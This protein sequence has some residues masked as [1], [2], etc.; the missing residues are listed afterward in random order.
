MHNLPKKKSTLNSP[1][2]KMQTL[3]LYKPQEQNP[4]SQISRES[5]KHNNFQILITENLI[6]KNPFNCTA[7]ES[8]L[9]HIFTIN[10]YQKQIKNIYLQG[11][12]DLDLRKDLQ[13]EKLITG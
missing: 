11:E 2:N 7:S 13:Y 12:I 5:S 9:N 8:C 3:G 4:T 6:P 1:R 10:Q